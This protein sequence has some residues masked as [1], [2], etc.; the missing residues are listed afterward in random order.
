MQRF[1]D[2]TLNGISN[3]AIFAAVGCRSG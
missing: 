1:I 3:G 2:L